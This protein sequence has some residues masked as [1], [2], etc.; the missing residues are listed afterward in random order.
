MVRVVQP[1]GVHDFQIAVYENTPDVSELEIERVVTAQVGKGYS[2]LV[3]VRSNRSGE[4]VFIFARPGR[5]ARVIELL[6]LAREREET[7]LVRLV[8]DAEIVGREMI[9]PAAMHKMASR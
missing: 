4:S 3:R 9:Q 5:D 2:R 8:A 7:V 6:I 1:S